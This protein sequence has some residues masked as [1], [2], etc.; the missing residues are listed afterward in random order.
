[1]KSAT[2]ERI[3]ITS[4]RCSFEETS[5]EN[6][7]RV[8]IGDYDYDFPRVYD[9]RLRLRLSS[10]S[11]LAI[12]ITIFIAIQVHSVDLSMLDA[13]HAKQEEVRAEKE[14]ARAM[15]PLQKLQGEKGD[16]ESLRKRWWW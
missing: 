2:C 16:E 10:R 8:I 9:W 13:A 7:P 6:F 11:S 1:M 4:I 12:T 14:K 15:T 3:S 5:F